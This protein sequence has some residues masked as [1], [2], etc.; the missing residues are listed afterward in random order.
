MATV[1]LARD[2]KH[3]RPVALKVLHPELAGALGADRFLR[4][5]KLTA[6]LDHPHILP[7]FDSGL[8]DGLLWYTM[9][10]VDGESLRERL[11]R[12]GQLPIDDAVRIVAEIADALDCAHGHGV[13]HRDVKPENVMLG[14]GH[15]RV[16]DFGVAR[17]LEAAGEEQLTATGLAVGTPAYMAPEQAS[18]G[19]VD[20]RTDIY[21]LGCVAYEM[22]A[23]EPPYTGPTPQAIIAKRFA[24]PIPSIRRLRPEVPEH[25]D[26]AIR[27]ALAG[28]P[29]D[30]FASVRGLSEALR[31]DHSVAS[32]TK[33]D[34][35]R[36]VSSFR[37]PWVV[38]GATVLIVA[39]AGVAWRL[40]RPGSPGIERIAVYP[41]AN[42]TADTSLAALGNLSADWIARA[43]AR[44]P[45]VELVTVPPVMADVSLAEASVGTGR[46]RLGKAAGAHT[47]IWGSIYRTGDSL[48]LVANLTD[49]SRGSLLATLEVLTPAGAPEPG[50]QSL[51]ER[52]TTS[53]LTA[54]SLDTT[55]M[56]MRSA[57]PPT[58]AAFQAFATNQSSPWHRR[59]CGVVL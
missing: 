51:A 29:A 36:L 14:G 55:E 59:V 57:R 2:L 46:D 17:A 40:M 18:A 34:P 53:V 15:A 54:R 30:R 37:R 56:L 48:R 20:A 32:A 50:I 11:R 19:P 35:R 5:I 44:V 9:P 1:Y 33:P 31:G 24:D 26:A 28:V 25:V 22:L 38:V 7:V 58:F 41:F 12:E 4:E 10:F 42:R 23:G 21:A 16:A 3:D 27:R 39:A 47:M 13:V 43:V 6:R 49:V 52:V 8:A 45:G